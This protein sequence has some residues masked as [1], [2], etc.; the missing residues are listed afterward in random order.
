MAFSN[1]KRNIALGRMDG[2]QRFKKGNWS[3]LQSPSIFVLPH[4]FIKRA[5]GPLVGKLKEGATGLS[6]VKVSKVG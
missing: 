1:S 4:Q 5:C 3:E 6:L 2:F